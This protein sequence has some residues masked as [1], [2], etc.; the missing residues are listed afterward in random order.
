MGTKRKYK[1]FVCPS[2]GERSVSVK[3]VDKM[4]LVSCSSCGILKRLSVNR[5]SENVDYFGDFIDWYE[6]KHKKPSKQM[7]LED[8]NKGFLEF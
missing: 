1:M 7:T 5:I 4:A 8:L 6:E 3:K 2:C